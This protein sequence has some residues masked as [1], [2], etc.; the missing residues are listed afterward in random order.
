[1][2]NTITI[3]LCAEDRA[4]LDSILDALTNQASPN[5]CTG[6]PEVKTEAPEVKTEV[7]EEPKEVKPQITLRDIQT[8]V[9]KLAAPSTGKFDQVKDIVKRFAPKVGQIPEDKFGE[10]MA[11]LDELEGVEA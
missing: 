9:Q 5:A 1:M 8:R 3:E 6:L 7:K 2:S 10:V 4:R 11:L